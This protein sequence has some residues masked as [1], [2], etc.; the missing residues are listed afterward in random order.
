MSILGPLF[1]MTEFELFANKLTFCFYWWNLKA[2]F[3]NSMLHRWS[4][5]RYAVILVTSRCSD[6]TTVWK[7][8]VHLGALFPTS[9]SVLVFHTILLRLFFKCLSS[10]ISFHVF[11]VMLLNFAFEEVSLIKRLF[12]YSDAVTIH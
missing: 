11:P 9:F 5:K 4:F 7:I 8:D 2:C 10:W 6:S 1:L 12:S 3:T